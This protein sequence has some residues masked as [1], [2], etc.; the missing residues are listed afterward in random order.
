MNRE[1]IVEAVCR[2]P[3]DFREKGNVSIPQLLELSG[4]VGVTDRITEEDLEACL[5]KSP[6]L[7]ESWI[8]QSEDNRGSPAWYIQEQD[9]SGNEIGAWVVG[10]YPNGTRETFP[11]RFRACAFYVKRFV[12]QVIASQR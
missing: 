5:R 6:G 7:V 10:R 9:V 2:L 11:D 1:Q 4:Y 3:K 12:E 8:A